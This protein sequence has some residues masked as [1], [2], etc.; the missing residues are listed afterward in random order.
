MDSLMA[1]RIRNTTRADFGVEPPVA[2]LLQGA[3]LQD[4]TAELVHQLGLGGHSQALEQHRRRPRP[5]TATRGGAPTSRDA[6][7]ARTTSMSTDARRR[8]GSL[9]DNAI[10]VIGMAGQIPGCQQVDRRSGTTCDA[11]KSRSSHSQSK[12]SGAAGVGDKVL[13]NP[14]YVRRAPL[15]DGIDEF[16][17]EFFGFPPQ[18]ARTHGSTTPIVPAVRMACVRGR[19]L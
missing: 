2:L 1:V 7:K 10:A 16:D 4:L 11:A 19:R 13:A 6:A 9:P 15:V 17:A 18:L 8:C 12:S 5:G 3:S 14:S